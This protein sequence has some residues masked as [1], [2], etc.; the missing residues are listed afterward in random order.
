MASSEPPSPP[1]KSNFY[2]KEWL[3]DHGFS[4][5]TAAFEEND[6]GQ[7]ELISL[8]EDNLK[9]LG[10]RSLGERKKILTQIALLRKSTLANK[11][12]LGALGTAGR[13]VLSLLLSALVGLVTCAQYSLAADI[14]NARYHYTTIRD[15]SIHVGIIMALAMLVSLGTA[16]IISIV[17]SRQSDADIQEAKF[18]AAASGGLIAILI[19]GTVGIASKQ[20]AACFVLSYGILSLFLIVA[21]RNTTK[22]LVARAG[23]VSAVIP[24]ISLLYTGADVDHPIFPLIALLIG[25]GCF[26]VVLYLC[27]R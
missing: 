8:T 19:M 3:A 9:E 25:W 2:T 15:I 10:V 18:F 11:L 27:R 5:Y 4:D 22:Q 7:E 12:A 6:I 26:F 23:I 17:K 20:V 24:I 1:L 21:H 16:S 13:I 14:F